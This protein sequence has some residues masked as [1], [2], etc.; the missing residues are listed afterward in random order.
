MALEL[1]RRLAHFSGTAIP[2]LYLAGVLPWRYVQYLVTGGAL[3]ALVLET[4]RLHWRLDWAIYDHLTREYERDNLAGYALAVFGATAVVW[5]FEPHV[6]VPAILMLTIADP[7]SGVLGS[8]SL[9]KPGY[10]LLVTFAVCVFIAS[11][12]VPLA[13][14]VTGALAATVAD[15]LK[16]VVAGYVI[17]DNVTIPVGSAGAMWLALAVL[18]ELGLVG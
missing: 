2:A 5:L 11:W 10:V 16:P 14:A 9:E 1:K 12:F 17:D 18:P 3:L 6:A 13:V 8:G 15:G 7:I 4:L